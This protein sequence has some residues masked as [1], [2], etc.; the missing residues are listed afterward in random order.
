MISFKTSY[1]RVS[2]FDNRKLK[3]I[4][5]GKARIGSPSIS[6]TS[7]TSVLTSTSAIADPTASG[8]SRL[9]PRSRYIFR[10]YYLSIVS[11]Y[12]CLKYV[13]IEYTGYH[14]AYRTLYIYE[15]AYLKLNEFSVIKKCL[16]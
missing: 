2:N 4:P 8:E 7:N 10:S 9:K 1:F 16:L 14:T 15:R 5:L 11:S 12:A 3:F 13:L 6:T